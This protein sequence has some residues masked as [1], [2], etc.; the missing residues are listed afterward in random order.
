MLER[1]LEVRF[2][3]VLERRGIVEADVRTDDRRVDDT[4]EI[5][6]DPVGLA[7]LQRMAGLALLGLAF[8]LLDVRLLQPVGD[9]RHLRRAAAGR[10]RS[11]LA[12]AVVS[13]VAI[14]KPGFAGSLGA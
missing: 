5:G 13:F 4:V 6:A 8:A 14:T 1:P 2:A 7:L 3:L 10:A 12:A 9:R 11:G